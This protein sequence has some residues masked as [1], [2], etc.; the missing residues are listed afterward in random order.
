MTFV[1]CQEL[2]D[3]HLLHAARWLKM[4]RAGPARCSSVWATS[5][6][7]PCTRSH[8]FV[9]GLSFSSLYDLNVDVPDNT[10]LCLLQLLQ[11]PGFVKPWAGGRL[12]WLCNVGRSGTLTLLPVFKEVPSH[13]RVP[14]DRKT[15][16]NGCF[17]RAAADF[18]PRGADNDGPSLSS[19]SGC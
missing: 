12:R 10:F 4:N 18:F 11:T 2:D 7:Q 9:P 8:V 5:A 19:S 6:K 17:I 14:E 1:C 13:S 15:H 16:L 3:L